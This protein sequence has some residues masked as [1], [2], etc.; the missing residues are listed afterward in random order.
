MQSRTISFACQKL[1][2]NAIC[3]LFATEIF[4]YGVHLAA[5][6][7]I[8]GKFLMN[9]FNYGSMKL[10]RCGE[11]FQPRP[12]TRSVSFVAQSY[13]SHNMGQKSVR[14]RQCKPELYSQG[15]FWHVWICYHLHGDVRKLVEND[16]SDYLF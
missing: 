11:R 4:F 7:M 10:L 6:E 2:C 1:R 5:R 8:D 16:I 3:W 13:L 12:V 14:H 9:G 15:L